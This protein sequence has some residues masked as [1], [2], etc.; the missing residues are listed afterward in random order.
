MNR[1][2]TLKTKSKDMFLSLLDEKI[3]KYFYLLK[4]TLSREIEKI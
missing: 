3:F 1:E 4:K 2:K